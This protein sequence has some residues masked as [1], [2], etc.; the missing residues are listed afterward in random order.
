M[1]VPGTGRVHEFGIASEIWQAVRRSAERHGGGRVLS[2]TMELGEMNLIQDEQL[3]FWVT[4][5]A[6]RDGSPGVALRISHIPAEARCRQCGEVRA[7][8]AK[9]TG[10]KGVEEASSRRAEDA[11]NDPRFPGGWYARPEGPCPRCGSLEVE[12]TGGREIRVVS[13]EIESSPLSS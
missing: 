13:A 2:I 1:T 12:V 6:E 11:G 3:R 5:L 10:P 4:A 8:F 9:A 7:P